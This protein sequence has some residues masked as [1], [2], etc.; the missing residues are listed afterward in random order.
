MSGGDR[1]KL[2]NICFAIR[3]HVRTTAPEAASARQ[4][5][6]AG[7][8]ALE[9]DGR[10]SSCWIWKGHSG[11]Q[12]PRIRMPRRSEKRFCI[13]HFDDPTQIHDGDTVTDLAHEMEIVSYEQQPETE[14]LLEVLEQVDD[15]GPDGDIEGRDRLIGD[16]E[17][18]LN[19]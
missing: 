3:D 6:G 10:G 11:D 7:W 19:S 12:G 4:V 5:E 14:A 18:R 13:G 9:A 8:L 15:L 17:V 1:H 2:W 16:D